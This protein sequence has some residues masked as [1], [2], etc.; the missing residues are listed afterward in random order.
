[1]AGGLLNLVSGGTQT[2]I[3]YGNPQKTYW[4]SSYKHITNFGIQNFRLEYEGQRKIQLTTDSIYTF[5]VKRYA[6][7]LTTTHLVM[8]LPDI[9]SP[10]YKTTTM[11][12]GV[13][14]T[15]YY[16][17]EFKWIKNLGAMMIRNI[18]FMIGGSLIQTLTGEDI[19]AFANRDLS[20]TTKSKW[21]AMT[22]NVPEL[23]DPASLHGNLYPNAVYMDPIGAPYVA[24]AEPSIRGREIRVP[25]PIWWGMTSQQ[26]FPLVCLQY[27]ELVIE[28]TL[29]PIS[30]LYQINN[31]IAD[32]TNGENFT[33]VIAPN[34]VQS[35]FQ[36]N[37][38]LNPPPVDGIYPPNTSWFE[39]I[40]LSCNYVFLSDE[41]AAMFASRTQSY[42][43]REVRDTW[44]HELNISDKVWLQQSSG[45]VLSW[46]MLFQRSDVNSRNEWS[47]FTN[48]PFSNIPVDIMPYPRMYTNDTDALD[49]INRPVYVTGERRPENIMDILLELGITVDGAVR[50][51]LKPISVY[52]YEQQYL[53]IKGL[54]HVGLPGLNCYHFCLHT[55]PFNL[56][57]SGAMNMSKYGKI[58]LEFITNTPLMN[59][60]GNYSVICDQVTGNQLGVSSTSASKSFIYYYNLLVIE[61]RY[62]VLVFMSGNAGLMNTR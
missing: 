49:S 17:Y 55:D 51:E 10:V 31:V 2:E 45:L 43:I 30:E 50:E 34:M 37:R 52:T 15:K 22:G 24:G 21:N 5:K 54:G 56:Q 29:R 12:D 58:E 32:Y 25:L 38:F 13:I 47:N 62:N 14:T 46:M 18:K 33:D 44:F 23:Y 4:T 27:N 57:P 53:T 6:E 1:M 3:V 60:L 9:Y 7:L 28:I 8:D 11:V 35:Q 40:H 19:V 61:E 59:P 20:G 39:N 41:E 16:P 36:F 48:W 42:L 26:A